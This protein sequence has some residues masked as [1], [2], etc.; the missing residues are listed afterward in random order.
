M[1]SAPASS[2]SRRTDQIHRP[3]LDSAFRTL[4]LSAGRAGGRDG[5]LRTGDSD[6]DLTDRAAVTGPGG[7]ASLTTAGR[8]PTAENQVHYPERAWFHFAASLRAYAG[9]RGTWCGADRGGQS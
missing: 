4:P 7:P 6:P 8:R 9:P 5:G 3:V 2:V 1:G